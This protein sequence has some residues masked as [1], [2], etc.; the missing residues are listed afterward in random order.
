M[1]YLI[2]LVVVAASAA[3]IHCAEREEQKS[4]EPEVVTIA[5]DMRS[6]IA[7]GVRDKIGIT[8]NAARDHDVNYP[9]ARPLYEALKEMGVKHIRYPGGEKSNQ[10]FWAQS[11]YTSPATQMWIPGWYAD[12]AVSR[13]T[14][15]FDEFMTL[16]QQTGAEAHINV[17]WNPSAGLD[18]SV[19]AA[20]VKYANITKG[21]GVK[22]WEIGN[23]MW[24]NKKLNDADIAAIAIEYS[25]AMKA[26]DPSI[27]V[28]ISC[29]GYQTVLQAA[30]DHLDFVTCSN[31]TVSQNWQSYNTYATATDM[32]LLENGGA[33]AINAVTADPT[34]TAI[35]TEFG[36]IDFYNKTWANTNDLGH[37]LVNFETIGQFLT[38]SKIAYG[39]LWTTRWYGEE[40]STYSIFTGVDNK[41]QLHP[42]A[43]AL[44]V[45]G[46]FMEDALVKIASTAS[47]RTYA[48]YNPVNGALN[49]FLENKA[50]SAQRVEI[51]IT[52]D[53]IYSAQ[54]QVWQLKGTGPGDRHPSWS[55]T[56]TVT[57]ANNVISGMELP[58]VS[59]T[60]IALI[61]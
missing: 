45:W 54:S 5:V 37:A 42:S 21:Y 46:K 33:S 28:G 13:T 34:R 41:N 16:C 55:S 12:Q 35:I 1:K 44:A 40:G 36:C 19:A 23:E 10:Y 57:P 8:I 30:G 26:I 7:S 48:A 47:I 25:T 4:T 9:G 56:G 50:T 39:C 29:K 15:N 43:M 22:Y 60:V 24:N 3:F 17:A 49:I 6:V 31:Y 53:K 14:M 2:V 52:S 11:P 51:P 32:N 20:W 18:K 38:Q 59:V 58:P 27:K 61:E